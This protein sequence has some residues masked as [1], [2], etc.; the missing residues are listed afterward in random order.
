MPNKEWTTHFQAHVLRVTNSWTGGAR[1][2]VDGDCRDTH[3]GLFAPTGTPA[4]SARLEQGNPES[5][6][7]E[8]FMSA[9]FT[10]KAALCVNGVQ[11]AGDALP[12]APNNSPQP[13]R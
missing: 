1:L 10:V 11:V 9:V 4:L 13:M 12:I 7:I 5:P 8:V 2:Y 6:L 3:N